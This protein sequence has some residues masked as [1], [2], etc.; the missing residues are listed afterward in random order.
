M[1]SLGFQI[2]INNEERILLFKDDCTCL[3]YLKMSH[4]MVGVAKATVLVLH[5]LS[6]LLKIAYIPFKKQELNICDIFFK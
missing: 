2:L 1:L 4:S 5:R 6:F 3:L